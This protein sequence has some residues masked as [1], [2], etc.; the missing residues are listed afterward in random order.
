MKPVPCGQMKAIIS[1][2]INLTNYKAILIES[3]L[4]PISTYTTYT[5]RNSTQMQ[6]LTSGSQRAVTAAAVHIV[7]IP[8]EFNWELAPTNY[9]YCC[10]IKLLYNNR[11]F[12]NN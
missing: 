9:E 11:K 6:K 8:S 10:L 5:M 1:K 2:T 4:I 3:H 12:Y 7:E